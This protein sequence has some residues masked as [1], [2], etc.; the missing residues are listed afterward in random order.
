MC[1]ALAVS[2]LSLPVAA[3]SGPGNDTS[4]LR[5]PAGASVAIVE[6][7]DLQCPACGHANPAIMQ[8]VAK[9]KIPW[10]R[11]DLLIP[12]HIWSPLAAV[13]ARWFDTK[14]PKLGEDY[15]N[16][17]FANQPSIETLYELRFFTE[18]FAQSHG[19]RLPP[20]VDPQGKLSAAVQADTALSRRTGIIQTPTVFVVTS[21]P[22][23]APYTRVLDIEHDLDRYVEQA[24]AA[25]RTITPA[26]SKKRA[27][28]SGRR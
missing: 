14:S 28:N 22:K 7:S 5:P 2:A 6:F 13:Y 12:G 26:S 19:V 15:R 1:V 18:Q 23:S 3:Q 10:V 4:A 9:Y 11:H 21:G 27:V 8:T 17:V 24:V 16:Q 20:D 25:N